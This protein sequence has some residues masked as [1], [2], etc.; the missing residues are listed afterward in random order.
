MKRWSCSQLQFHVFHDALPPLFGQSLLCLWHTNLVHETMGN[1]IGSSYLTTKCMRNSGV[2]F[3]FLV[4]LLLLPRCRARSSLF[5]AGET[6]LQMLRRLSYQLGSVGDVDLSP[7]IRWTKSVTNNIL[8]KHW[9]KISADPYM[10]NISVSFL[11]NETFVCC[12]VCAHML[13][14]VSQME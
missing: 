13:S 12:T 6:K 8:A 5:F 4:S 7:K 14:S 1:L 9:A 3:A 11:S 2:D 10:A